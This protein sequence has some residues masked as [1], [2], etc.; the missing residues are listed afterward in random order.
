MSD[1][2]LARFLDLLTQENRRWLESQSREV[3]L[4]LNEQFAT[5]RRAEDPQEANAIVERH[6]AEH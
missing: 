2:D 5:T 6:R 4:K 3:Q 1:V